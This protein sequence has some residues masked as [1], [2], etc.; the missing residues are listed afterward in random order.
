LENNLKK[1]EEDL[2]KWLKNAKKIAV[3]G[4]GNVYRKDDGVGS[5]II[6]KLEEYSL[7]ENV[8]LFNCETVPENFT[9][10]VRSFNP[11]H[12]ILVDSALLNQKPGTVKLVSP[13]KIGGITVSTHTLPLTFLVKYFEEFIGAKTVLVA[14]QPKN[15]DFGF[16]LTVEVEKTLRNLVKVLVRIFK[17]YG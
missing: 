8:K 2:K 13:E 7:P 3:L 4:I 10:A 9:Y 15:V 11:T 16:G 6:Q 14:I 12:I 17:N 1:L 5:L